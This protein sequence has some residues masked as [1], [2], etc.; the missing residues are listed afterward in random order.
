MTNSSHYTAVDHSLIHFAFRLI[1]T[2]YIYRLGNDSA[3][4]LGKMLQKNRSLQRLDISSNMLR[5][6]GM[7]LFLQGLR[8]RCDTTNDWGVNNPT[9]LGSLFS[10]LSVLQKNC[11]LMYVKMAKNGVGLECSNELAKLIKDN[12]TLRELDVSDCRIP[13]AGALP[14]ARA[15]RFNTSLQS[16]NV[17]YYSTKYPSNMMGT[18]VLGTGLLTYWVLTYNV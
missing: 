9:A 10:D 1:L 15:F 4:E 14:I 18:Y 16:L 11:G 2:N 8:V 6:R 7:L 5:L 13:L 17:C 12:G 3:V